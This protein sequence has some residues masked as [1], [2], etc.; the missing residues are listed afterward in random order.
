MQLIK[1]IKEIRIGEM[2]QKTLIIFLFVFNS[3]VKDKPV[4]ITPTTVA[5]SGSK[6]VYVI[7]EGPFQSGGNGS[8]SLYNVET[9]AVI[10][11][12]YKEQNNAEVG[13]IAQ[14]LSFINSK[15]YI[16]V[17]NSQKI[18][19]CTNEFK[20][21]GEIN[22]LTSPRYILPITNQKAYVSDLYA[23]AISIIDLNSNTKIG[24]IP[25]SGKTEKM[26]LI[27][28]KAFVTNSDRDYVYIINT[29][30]DLKTDSVFVGKNSGSIVLDKND[31]VWVLSS[32]NQQN[33][34]GKL[35]RI[36]PISNQK[37]VEMSFSVSDSPNNLCLNKT[38][39]TL[40]FL[41]EGIFRIPV[42]DNSLPANPFVTK[43]N[44]NFYGLGINPNNCTIYAADALD[45]SQKSN[46]YIYDSNGNQKSLFKAGVISNGFYFE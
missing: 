10:E 38:K 3:C 44:R 7:N 22:G 28:N 20:K 19:V 35:I 31:K 42:I 23:N 12:Y 24:S 39:D 16:V 34:T 11:N 32:G 43:G 2:V 17:N 25:C 4:K 14:S 18:I 15:F 6:K 36:N 46:I 33:S 5:F 9:G 37:E 41:N 30:T 13:N 27:Y 45:Y 26:T 40:Y 1:D 8:I 29:I 21:T